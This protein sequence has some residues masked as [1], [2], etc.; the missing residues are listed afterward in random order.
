M[1]KRDVFCKY[2]R[3]LVNRD[4]MYIRMYAREAQD[5]PSRNVRRI[6]TS[7]CINDR[8]SARLQKLAERAGAPHARCVRG[9]SMCAADVSLSLSLSLVNE[10]EAGTKYRK[11]ARGHV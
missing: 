4:E 5:V 9:T 7:L 2:I 10:A 6:I 1:A 8:L 11:N 3:Q